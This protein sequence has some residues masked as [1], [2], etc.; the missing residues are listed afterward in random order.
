V[1]GKSGDARSGPV[2]PDPGRVS[3]DAGPSR[4][5]EIFGETAGVLIGLLIAVGIVVLIMKLPDP[6]KGKYISSR[7]DDSGWGLAG[8]LLGGLFDG[9]SVV[10]SFS[11]GGGMSGGGGATGSW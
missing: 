11:G 7:N 8:T 6:P 5:W 4:F 3:S 2:A 1:A 9:I 10:S